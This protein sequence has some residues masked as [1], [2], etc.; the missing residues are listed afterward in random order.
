MA[1][2]RARRIPLSYIIGEAEF[3]G[4]PFEVGE[5]CLIPRPETELLVEEMLR[6]C[7]E[8]SRFADWCTGSGCIGICVENDDL[9]GYGRL[10]RDSTTLGSLNA[11]I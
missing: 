2:K 9:S 11:K 6:A 1:E 3:Y 4:R 7:P 8:A 10:Q 5:G